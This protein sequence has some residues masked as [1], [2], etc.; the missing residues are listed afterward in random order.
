M[1]RTARYIEANGYYHV[2]SRSI[3]ETRIFRDRGDFLHFRKLEQDAKRKFP[4]QLF[5]YVFM[6]THFHF[7]LQ[8]TAQQS[9][10][11]HLAYIKWHYTLWMRKK[12]GW[13]GPLWRERY[14]SLPIENEAYLTA[15]GMYVEFNPVRAGLCRAPTDYPY[16]SARHY[17][18]GITDDL[19]DRQT[20][21]ATPESSI[22]VNYSSPE[23]KSLFSHAPAIGG[24]VFIQ[25][26]RGKRNACP[27]K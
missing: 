20:L 1:P 16:S 23:S 24:A 27:K 17:H 12:Y 3:N 25:Y 18:L 11:H 14:K 2:I 13:K 26:H 19:L 22:P 6:N 9:L 10:S 7:V 5:H 8:A 15:C 21:A 4:I